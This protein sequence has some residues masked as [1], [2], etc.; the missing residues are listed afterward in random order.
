MKEPDSA[1][2]TLEKALKAGNGKIVI[3]DTEVEMRLVTGM[4][5]CYLNFFDRLIIVIISIYLLVLFID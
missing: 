2:P 3:K 4:S 1:A 5:F